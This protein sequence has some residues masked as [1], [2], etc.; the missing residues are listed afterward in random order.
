M[1]I[2]IEN[3]SGRR[4]QLATRTLIGRTRHADLRISGRWV[5]GEHAVIWWTGTAWHIRDLGSR[6]GTMVGGQR[7]P[8]PGTQRLEAGAEISFGQ[9]EAGWRLADVSPPRAQA[10][11]SEGTTRDAID[12]VIVLP[13]EEHAWAVV[14]RT[15]DG[16]QVRDTSGAR[17]VIDRDTIIV[18]Q[19]TWTL[20]LPG[21]AEPTQEHGA[22]LRE[23]SSFTLSLRVSRDEE[24][25]DVRL[26]HEA[27]SINLAPRA[28][29]ELLL[30]LAEQL[31]A[32]RETDTSIPEAGWIDTRT[33]AQQLGTTRDHLNVH[34]R[35]LR[36]QV[37][38]AGVLGAKAI[39][40][41]RS[42]AGQLRLYPL[43]VE[44]E[45]L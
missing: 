44:I 11:S 41:R 22:S 31:E 16:W 20:R 29:H 2:L 8:P 28:H 19:Q 5:S 30:R 33:L 40:E 4:V 1:G 10:R 17:R 26:L 32:D 21:G 35:R 14:E 45:R 42:G 3:G 43:P 25:I 6:N 34:V 36:Q 27:S 7:L 39:V 23:L 18:G 12:E 15:E 37:I 9:V 38:R 24:S 13:D